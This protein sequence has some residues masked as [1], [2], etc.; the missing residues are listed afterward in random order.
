MTP[1]PW[2]EGYYTYAAL[3]LGY[4][5][6]LGQLWVTMFIIYSNRSFSDEG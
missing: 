6:D 5:L 1:Q 2:E 4:S 3:R